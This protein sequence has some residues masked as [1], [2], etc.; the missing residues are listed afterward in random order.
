[1]N[2]LLI[3]RRGMMGAQGG[4]LPYDAEIE[5]LQCSGAQWIDTG[6]APVGAIIEGT[7][8]VSFDNK[9]DIMGVISVYGTN[10][11]RYYLI[12]QQTSMILCCKFSGNW[13]TSKVAKVTNYNANTFYTIKGTMTTTNVKIEVGSLNNT[14]TQTN[15]TTDTRTFALMA[16]NMQQTREAG[17]VT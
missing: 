5:Y 10:S 14:Y 3:R 9:N 17:S 12:E 4:G 15:T 11:T 6:I 8:V 13:N 7:S 1:M 2:P 16:R